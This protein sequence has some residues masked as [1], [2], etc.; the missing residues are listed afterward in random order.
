[1]KHFYKFFIFSS[2]YYAVFIFCFFQRIPK[3]F[4]LVKDG[5]SY[6]VEYSLPEYKTSNVKGGNENFT[7]LEIPEYGVTYQVGKPQL[8]Q[9]SFFLL[10]GKNESSPAVQVIGQNKSIIPLKSLLFPT[11]MP[12]EKT[13]RL[14][15]RPFV[16]DRNY[17]SSTGSANAPFVT[18]SEP[19]IM[20]GAKGVMVTIYPF[21]YNPSLNELRATVNGSFNEFNCNILHLLIFLQDLLWMNSLRAILLTMNLKIQKE[22]III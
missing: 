17:Y 4:K 22:Q 21:N 10:V 5:N 7:L 18:V 9:I 16:I 8:P 11:Q 19:F 15:D 12:W 13:K 14:E 6:I 1:M 20:G 2:L 3:R